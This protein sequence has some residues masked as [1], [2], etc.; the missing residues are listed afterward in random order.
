MVTSSGQSALNNTSLYHQY[1]IHQQL[2]KTQNRIICTLLLTRSSIFP[3]ATPSPIF[4]IQDKFW[5][6]HFFH[7]SAFPFY[8]VLSLLGLTLK[9]SSDNLLL[10]PSILTRRCINLKRSLNYY[11]DYCCLDSNNLAFACDPPAHFIGFEI[12]I[13]VWICVCMSHSQTRLIAIACSTAH[14]HR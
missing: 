2:T 8:V 14:A 9:E 7:N 10:R 11:K 5:N 12:S 13:S 6:V 4:A 1:H 3:F